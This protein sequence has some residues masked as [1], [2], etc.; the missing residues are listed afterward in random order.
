MNLYFQIARTTYKPL[1]SE[2]CQHPSDGCSYGI[3]NKRKGVAPK[4][5]ATQRQSLHVRYRE[6]K[7]T[8]LIM[9]IFAIILA[10]GCSSRSTPPPPLD[11]SM[12]LDA[13]EPDKVPY[14]DPSLPAGD[15]ETATEV[16]RKNFEKL[17]HERLKKQQQEIDDLRRQKFQNGYYNSRYPSDGQ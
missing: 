11:R 17:Q 7:R 13:H 5:R 15:L 4:Q 14:V 16:E 3:S 12:D 6:M 8:H 9:V 10:A 2:Q 1:E